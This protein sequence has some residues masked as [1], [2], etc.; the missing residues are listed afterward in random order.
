MGKIWTLGAVAPNNRGLYPSPARNEIRLVGKMFCVDANENVARRL[1]D[2]RYDLRYS[3]I[4][5]QAPVKILFRRE[6]I[7]SSDKPKSL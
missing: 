1:Y 6:L 3:V 4:Q 2:R 7:A 5:M